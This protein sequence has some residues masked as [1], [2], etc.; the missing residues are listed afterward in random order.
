MH[1]RYDLRINVQQIEASALS[2]HVFET[3]VSDFE[4]ASRFVLANVVADSV[5]PNQPFAVDGTFCCKVHVYCY[6]EIISQL[7]D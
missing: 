6:N 5:A 4:S 3:V 2:P 7:L 1:F